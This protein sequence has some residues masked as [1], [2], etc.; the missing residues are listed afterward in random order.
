MA[1]F[2]NITLEVADR[3]ATITVDRPKALNALNPDT[4]RELSDAIDR[5]AKDD[6]VKVV[7]VTGAGDKAFVAGADIAAMVDMDEAGGRGFGEAGHAV[8]RKLE[9]L[10]K[11]VIAAV[12][13]FALGGGTELA[14]ACDI[15]LASDHAVFGQ[16]EIKLGIIPGFGGTQR[17]ARKCGANVAKEMILSGNNVK[18][19]RALQIGLANAVVPAADLMDE[20]LKLAG[21][22]ASYGAVALAAAKRAIDEGLD[23]A[24]IDDGLQVEQDAFAGLFS[25]EDRTEGMKAFIEKR[26]PDFKDR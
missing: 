6:G 25:T 3:I 23:K 12:N 17:L 14:L 7:I 16:P 4:L 19:D 1:D 24:K 18:A 22:L 8:M 20:A 11:P 9:R 21:K 10:P 26:K 15:I 2:Q 13:G 5:V